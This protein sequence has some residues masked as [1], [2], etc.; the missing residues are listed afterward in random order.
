MEEH[1][2]DSVEQALRAREA[3]YRAAE[4]Q[5]RLVTRQARCVLLYGM[6]SAPANWRAWEFG[7]KWEF[8]WSGVDVVSVEAAQEV[9]PLDL[10]PGQ[11]YLDAWNESRHP[12]DRGLA[13]EHA[14]H[15]LLHD[16]PTFTNALR[17][18]DRHGVEHWLQEVATLHRLD[19]CHWQVISI[20]TDI[21]AL[22]EAEEQLR[23]VARQA[24]CVLLSG[25]VEAVPGWRQWQP[26]QPSPFDWHG[27]DVVSEE[28]AQEVLPLDVA[29]GQTYLEAWSTSRREEDSALAYE[30]AMHAF[31]HGEPN[32]T[33]TF[34]C[35]DRHGVDH[36]LQEVLTL[37]ALDDRHWSCISIATDIT[38]LKEAEEAA[39]VGAEQLR[40]VTRHTR[41]IL[42]AGVVEGA[43]D[44][45]ERALDPDRDPF[46][47][48]HVHILNPEAA[49]DVLPL[50]VAPGDTYESALAPAINAEDQRQHMANAGR[51]FLLGEP[52]QRAEFRFMDRHG[53]LHWLQRI[54]TVQP[55]DECHW[56][57]FAIA[58]DVTELK[59]VEE[60]ARIGSE[61]L[62][63]VTRHARCILNSG[64]VEGDA[65][66][67]ARALDADDNPF[68]WTEVQIL[69]V[70][71]A[72]EVLPLEVAPG[73]TY[74]DAMAR[75]R[76]P[77]DTRVAN[78]NVGRALLAGEPSYR[79]EFRCTDRD[80]RRHWLQ[81]V[82]TVQIVDE[83]RWR[84]FGITTDITALKEAE[85]ERRAGEELLLSA[86]HI[87]GLGVFDYDLRRDAYYM[88]DRT[89][90]LWGVGPDEPVSGSL[91]EERMDAA[92]YAELQA[93]L[94]RAAQPGSDGN[95]HHESLI[96]LPDGSER[97]LSAR[98]RVFFEDGRPVRRVGTTLDITESKRAEEELRTVLTNARCML[99]HADVHGLPGWRDA[100][101]S[102]WPWFVWNLKVQDEYAAQSVLPLDLPAGGDYIQAWNDSR[103]EGELAHMAATA[104]R[105]FRD[106]ARGYAQEFRCRDKTG[107]LV[108]LHEETTIQSLGP[109][110]WRVFGVV[111]DVTERKHA[112]EELRAVLTNARCILWQAD[113][114]AKPGWREADARD[115]TLIDWGLRVQDE[116]A[117]QSVLPLDVP[118][119]STYIQA[120][121][122]SRLPGERAAMAVAA[123]RAFREGARGYAQEFQCRD[124]HGRLVWLREE[125]TIAP[126][127][128]DH[129]R[130]FGVVTDVTERKHAEEELRAVLTNTRCILWQAEVRA[131]S[132]WREAAEDDPTAFEWYLTVQDEAA[133]QHV[134]PL[135]VPPGSTYH[136]AWT[137]S[138]V[139]EDRAWMDAG[140]AGPFRRGERGY[141][142]EF[143]CRDRHGRIV[144][145]REE[146]TIAALGADRWRVFGVVTDVTERKHAEEEL[147]AVL[148]NARCILW[149]AEVQAFP[150]WR[151]AAEDDWRVFD[152][153]LKVQDEAA[154]QQVLPLDVPASS[155]YHL[156]WTFSRLDEHQSAMDATACRALRAGDGGYTQEFRCRDRHGRIVW[157]R[158]E[159]TIQ[160]LGAD[161]WRVF[162]VV[163][164]VTDRK[165]AEEELRAVL[166]NARCMLWH[167][168]VHG[169]PGWREADE[170]DARCLTWDTHL[171]DEGAAQ[172]MLPLDVPAG[173][174]YQTACLAARLDEDRPAMAAGCHRA[175][176]LGLGGYAQD[177]RCRDRDGRLLWL[178]EDA[179]IQPLG[180][181]RW[182]VFGVVTDITERKQ[183]EEERL[184]IERHLQ[185][186][187]RLESLGVLAGGIAHDFNNLLMGILGNAELAEATAMVDADSAVCLANI[188]TAAH[189]AAELCRQMLA[190]AG[191]GRL[192]NEA[193]DLRL[194]TTE[195]AELLRASISKRSR[196]LLSLPDTLP[197]VHGDASQLRQVVMNLV[198]NA[199]EA[200]GEEDGVVR[201]SAETVTCGAGE[202]AALPGSEPL[203]A[204]TYLLLE[205]TDTGC[206]IAPDD[207]QRI[208]EPFYT[209]KFTG[210]GL[211]L[212]AVVGIVRGHRGTLEVI[213]EA[214][215]G[216]TFRLYLPA[217]ESAPSP[218]PESFAPAVARLEGTVLL[219]DDEDIVRE[220]STRILESFGLKVMVAVDGQEAVE[221]YGA[222]WEEIDVVLLDL[223]M[224]RLNGEQA[225]RRLC[226]INPGV[227][228]I[229]SSGYGEADLSRRFTGPSLVGVIQKPFRV[230]TLRKLLLPLFAPPREGG[231]P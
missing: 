222:H 194:L 123:H 192:S 21:T 121:I 168:E 100:D 198:L 58:T 182:R 204:G 27:V 178:R 162:G 160:P 40:L 22:K 97:W 230:L 202:L 214:G 154:A 45:R 221:L 152:W 203:A 30:R 105:A 3:Q 104:H 135:D 67:R 86:K 126:L 173:S 140:A 220:T 139:D 167:A 119:G 213:S 164:D 120:W 93:R 170:T 145:L 148:T 118:E 89:R 112:E 179:T 161:R 208:F 11:S 92:G 39:R 228:V 68:W 227:R 10:A 180:P 82:V 98:G 41:C 211:G 46:R 231:A 216:T 24:R 117:A 15:A 144:W 19:D 129:W 62:R 56:Q 187:Q 14:F 108:W 175:F 159:T 18:R 226:D 116:S 36:W 155:N 225:Y 5:H 149:Q 106:G 57:I 7:G 224:P 32:F 212:S 205:V 48:A 51:A 55:L 142:Q 158:E 13:H 4:E 128:P 88:D 183:A 176:R 218:P 133:A 29:P 165:Q 217:S 84:I 85:E 131:A 94:A 52:A 196:L 77:D 199:S 171:Q 87:S 156:A 79:N 47:W 134:L 210:R 206:G 107:R 70:E 163:T 80:G 207:V 59:A 174:D 127:E 75:A 83:R 166:T 49:Q 78:L 43:P 172:L 54:M 229:V 111:T 143:R 137:D 197:P 31:L 125:T 150:G 42:S 95:Y 91:I 209:T 9:L 17:C 153:K 71:A 53:R 132:G 63:S 223:T 147:R 44:W 219:V 96:R 102:D 141:A 151:E 74:K 69:N 60:A 1:V 188:K 33:N 130:V 64:V 76:H 136:A 169:L 35:R 181:D 99:W 38:A 16:E 184:Q 113:A 177:F 190:Y 34:R 73:E 101:Q 189:R 23:L 146:A 110:H 2:P 138:R 115:W 90:E 26:G 122:E 201:V 191:K 114:R 200:I 215:R 6:L 157:L 12:E 109:D 65:D 81:Q 25:V 195:L 66:W 28:A 37:R 20:S 50:D 185:Q 193:V 61:Q 103:L 72:Q 124:R 186:S 8:D